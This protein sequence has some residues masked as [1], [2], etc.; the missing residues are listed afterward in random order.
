MACVAVNLGIL[1]LRALEIVPYSS[2]VVNMT[3][4][5]LRMLSV[6]H[7]CHSILTLWHSVCKIHL[8]MCMYNLCSVCFLSVCPL[9]CLTLT[10]HRVLPQNTE[11]WK[12]RH[13]LDIFG[14]LC[15][16]SLPSAGS[17]SSLL[18]TA[19]ATCTGHGLTCDRSSGAWFDDAGST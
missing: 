12:R 10:I 11:W 1:S 7:Q 9:P 3:T 18:S 17:Y 19:G 13:M 5:T 4:G 8:E 16:A 15:G 2:G 14:S 6:C